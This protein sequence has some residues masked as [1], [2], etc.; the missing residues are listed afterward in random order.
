[1]STHEGLL[2]GPTAHPSADGL[3]NDLE[4]EGGCN[5]GARSPAPSRGM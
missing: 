3:G 1:M 2:R 4:C 5:E